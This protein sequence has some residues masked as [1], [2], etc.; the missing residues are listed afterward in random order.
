[1]PDADRM[2]AALVKRLIG[3]PIR[4]QLALVTFVLA[5]P[6]VI[7][8]LWSGL[9]LRGDAQAAARK[10]VQDLAAEIA[11]TQENLVAAA[12]QLLLVLSEL[13]ELREHRTAEVEAILRS[14]LRLSD[15]YSNIFVADREGRVW[16]SAVPIQTFQVADRLYFRSALEAGRLAAGEYVMSR[17]TGRPA[18]NLGY[19]I[20]DG[21][22][23]FSGVIAIGFNLERYRRFLEGSRAS[24]DTSYLLLDHAGTVLGRGVNPG[25]ILGK[26]YDEEGFRRMVEGPDGDILVARSMA[27]DVRLIAYRKLRLAGTADPYLYVRVGTPVATVTARA[28]RALLANVAVFVPFLLVALLLAGV[29]AE[30]AIVERTKQLQ[31]AA[32][33]VAGGEL[34]VRVADSIAGG[35]LGALALAFDEMAAS[36]QARE[37]ARAEAEAR[38][39]ALEE[40]LRHS[41]RLEAVGRLA[42]GVAHDFNNLLTAIRGSSDLLLEDLPP[43]SPLRAE[44]VEIGRAVDRATSLTRQ[45]LAFSRRQVISPAVL[46]PNRALRESYRMLTRLVREDV[47]IVLEPGAG[48][49]SVRVDPHQL[50][51]ALANLTVNARDAMPSG[52]TITISTS[53]VE[54]LA[55]AAPPGGRPGR[56]VV[57]AFRDDGQ[58]IPPEVQAHLFEPFFTTKAPGKGTGLGLA[59]VYGIVE[60]SGGFVTV[61]SA[62]GAGTTFRIHLPRVD[63]P[64]VR[65]AEPDRG[66][67]AAPRGTETI[68]V[69]EDEP[70]VLRVAKEALERQGYRTLVAAGPGEALELVRARGDGIALL[71]TD[72][73]MPGMNGSELVAAAREIVPG[74][75]ALYMS[76]YGVHILAPH[77]A[78]A[79]GIELLQKPFTADAL[80][81]RVRDVLDGPVA[82]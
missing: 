11:F 2:S 68:L 70:A 50:D 56:W 76:G 8:I 69:V 16:A 31:R 12:G 53:E 51:H 3:L 32:A 57:I 36:L 41:Q 21:R 33:R 40:Q 7:V 42:G 59:T 82:A 25:P 17:A 78:L 37:L 63:E 72:V 23:G 5:A 39:A 6:A 26:R 44:V 20:P 75:K 79:P 43:D 80:V 13:P 71:L 10:E 62:P 48:I 64:A 67:A 1:M 35:E 45:L 4:W 58:G 15:Q 27:G 49:G 47:R 34:S 9:R 22:G 77:G 81:C 52:G 24:P 54:I 60:Q 29:L 38:R 73:V 18:F 30:R 28:N 61:D 19:P 55:G 46:D 65:A 74:L 66:A 14:C